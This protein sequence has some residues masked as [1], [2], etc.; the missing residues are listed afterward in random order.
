MKSILDKPSDVPTQAEINEAW[1]ICFDLGKAGTSLLQRRMKINYAKA[2][3]IIDHLEEI[4][5]IEMFNPK[6]PR[7]VLLAP[8]KEVWNNSIGLRTGEAPTKEER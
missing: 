3:R 1:K 4:G 7:K 8:A 6:R 5:A 2:F